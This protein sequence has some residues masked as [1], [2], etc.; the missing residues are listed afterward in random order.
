MKPNTIPVTCGIALALMCAIVTTHWMSVRQ[1]LELAEISRLPD[2]HPL[3]TDTA[4]RL[5]PILPEKTKL[6]ANNTVATKKTEPV[7]ADD[8]QK[9]DK[10]LRIVESLE[11]QNQDLR[12]QQG[13]TNRDLMEL[14][15]RVDTHSESFRPLRTTQSPETA[16]DQAPGVLPP[17]E[18][19]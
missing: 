4:K 12:E 2:I 14:Q 11:R 6:S 1:L 9:I 17:R 18:Q 5:N 13:E 10:L 3:Q 16:Y 7:P 19:P 8:P 15:F